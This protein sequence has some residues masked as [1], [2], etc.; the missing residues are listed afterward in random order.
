MLNL[1]SFATLLSCSR[2]WCT[3]TLLVM[4][5]LT[6][7][8]ANGQTTIISPSGAGGFELG[9]TFGDN[10]WTVVNGTATSTQNQWILGLSTT[11]NV[12]TGNCA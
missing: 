9:S 4:L 1:D 2:Q 7:G 8:D 12:G 5:L 6:I 11:T 3:T 10:G